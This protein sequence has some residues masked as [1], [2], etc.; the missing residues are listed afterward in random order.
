MIMEL[1]GDYKNQINR[2]KNNFTII[3]INWFI[4]S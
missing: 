2:F 4:K 3:G 1:G